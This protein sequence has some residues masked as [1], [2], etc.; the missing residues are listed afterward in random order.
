MLF[1]TKKDR[2]QAVVEVVTKVPGLFPIILDILDHRW[3]E[4]PFEHHHLPMPY[5]G[6][7]YSVHLHMYPPCCW[8]QKR[9]SLERI[10]SSVRLLPNALMGPGSHLAPIDNNPPLLGWKF[11]PSGAR[12]S[13]PRTGGRCSPLRSRSKRRRLCPRTKREGGLG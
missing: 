2:T 8:R 11:M 7:D 10:N 12:G 1:T 4:T 13:C 3:Y 9:L 6:V 5:R